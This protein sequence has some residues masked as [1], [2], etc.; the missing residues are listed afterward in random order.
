MVRKKIGVSGGGRNSKLVIRVSGE[1]KKII[2]KYLKYNICDIK[3]K[4]YKYKYI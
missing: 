4:L 2:Q 1:Q 3:S